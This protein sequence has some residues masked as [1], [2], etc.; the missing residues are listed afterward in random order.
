MPVTFE[1]FRSWQNG[2]TH[3]MKKTFYA[4]VGWMAWRLG[5]RYLGGKLRI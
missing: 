2:N 5:R 3:D 4:V 1:M